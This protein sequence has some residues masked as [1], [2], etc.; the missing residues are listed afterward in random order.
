M[1]YNAHTLEEMRKYD[2]RFDSVG[3]ELNIPGP[4]KIDKVKLKSMR[5]DYSMTLGV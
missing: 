5:G 1:T 2:R 3:V 4:H